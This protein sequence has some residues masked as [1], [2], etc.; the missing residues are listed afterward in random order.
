MAWSLTENDS[1]RTS[2]EQETELTY[3]ICHQDKTPGQ[4]VLPVTLTTGNCV[5]LSKIQTLLLCDFCFSHKS[6]LRSLRNK[7]AVS[8]SKLT[9][10]TMLRPT[11]HLPPKF[12]KNIEEVTYIV[13]GSQVI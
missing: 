1:L 12:L 5:L 2:Q 7:S 8:I 3:M 11:K 13:C 10:L 6:V 4:L 9:P